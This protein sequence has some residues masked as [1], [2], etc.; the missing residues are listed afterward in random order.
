MLHKTAWYYLALRV[1]VNNETMI[2]FHDYEFSEAET[3]HT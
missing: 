1:R 2:D 3:T